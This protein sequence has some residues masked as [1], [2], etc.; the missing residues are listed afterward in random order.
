LPIL[1]KS[2]STLRVVGDDL[3]PADV[4]KLLKCEPT[5]SHL[6]GHTDVLASGTVR[7]RKTGL[8]KVTTADA[9]P[10][11]LDGQV[12]E[13]L[14]K[15]TDD[16]SAWKELNSRYDVDLFCGWFMIETNEG[17]EISPTTMSKLAERGIKVDLDLYGP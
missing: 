3:V 17:I 16:L 9:I 14:G 11:D 15:M 4:S 1:S 6:K 8:W 13:L 5:Y 7:V 10:G 2:V 12:A